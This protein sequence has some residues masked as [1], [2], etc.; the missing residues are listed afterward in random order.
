MSN[1]NG[2]KFEFLEIGENSDF[3]FSYNLVEYSTV[4]NLLL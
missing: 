2:A 3:L 4:S 1:E